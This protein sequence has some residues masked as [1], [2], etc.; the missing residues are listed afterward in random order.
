MSWQ[1]EPLSAL[2]LK[3]GSGSTPRG[4]DSVYISEG[5]TLIRSQNVYNN[6]FSTDGLVYIDEKTA[7]KMK[8]VS[9]EKEDVLVNITGDSVARCCLVHDAVLPA[10]VNQHVA[11]LR[12]NPKKLLPHFLAFYMVSPFMQAKMLSWAGTGGT[13]K[14]LTKGMLEGFEIP[15]P[16]V[17]V[18]DKIVQKIKTYNDLIENNRRRI[19]LLEES[20]RLLYQE[21]FVHLRFPGHKQVKI[22]DGVPEGWSKEPLENL[23]VLQRGFDLPVSKRIEG[24]V[25]IYAS[26]GINGFHNVAKVKGPGVVTGRSGSLGT[27]M[28]VAKDYWPLNTTLWVKEFKKA[29]P[30][31]A[32]YLLRAMKLEGY[33]GGAAV[34]TLNR[35]DVHKVDVLCP[36]SKLMNKFEV[37]VENIFKQIDK[38]KEYNEK[39]AQARDLL[40][41]KLMSGELT[42]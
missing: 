38:L 17:D 37:Q 5:T 30:I 7:E 39:L 26:T 29:S 33:N 12:T 36:E 16:P 13:R 25:P 20:A 9:V 32:T 11:I 14:A 3:I 15:L 1:S 19:Q 18:Q 27:V 21:W 35:N 28:Y 22:T 24:S 40:L 34:P 23:L 2:T 31:F 8:G 10:R 6:E 41:P 42:V 4:G